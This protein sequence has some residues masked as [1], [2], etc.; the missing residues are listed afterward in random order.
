MKS[1]QPTLKKITWLVLPLSAVGLGLLLANGC[2][3]ETAST[4]STQPVVSA[5]KNSFK[6]VT[7]RLDP[8]GS[9]Y[10]Y[11][12]TE[13]LLANLSD[14]VSAW[15]QTVLSMPN[16]NDEARGNVARAFDAAT[17]LIAQSG[18]EDVSGF[19]M[20]SIATE[21]G[22][23]H[24]KAFLHHYPDKGT[25]FLWKIMGQQPH[26]LTGLEMLPTNTAMATFSDADL[27]LVWSVIQKQASQSGFPQA[28]DF[29]NKLPEE[30]QKVTGLSL[31]TV[32]NSLGGEFGFVITLDPSRMIPVPLP[33]SEPLQVPEPGLMLV[34]K[35]K[36]DTVFNRIDQELS[37]RNRQIVRI[38]KSNLKMRTMPLPLP[39]PIQLRP[40]I[41][42]SDGYLFVATTDTLIQEVLAVK[43]GQKPGLKATDEFKHLAKDMP[44][45]GNRFVFMSE[46]FGRTILQIQ[47]ET[48]QRNGKVQPAQQQLLQSLFQPGTAGFCYSVSANT[49]EGW[50]TVG[51][52]SQSP[53]NTLVAFS[54][55][56]PAA[57]AA[58]AIPNFVKAR[59]VAQK[60]ACI[61]NL[62]QLDA[63]KAQWALENN[64]TGND[65]PTMDDLRPF[66]KGKISCPAGGHYTLGTVADR[67]TC[68]IPGH[69]LEH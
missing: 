6:E 22:L 45:E 64:K 54:A 7:S 20:S 44:V 52:S 25:G 59:E 17:N 55:A 34:V 42:S 49:D 13:Q 63:A 51:N 27:P 1:N 62:R 41:A 39:L 24:S 67:P 9:L 14:R 28:Q 47:R 5:E 53:A 43:S 31:E 60:N 65:M 57:L 16:L 48:L 23:Y 21:P 8:G 12:S 40:T 19:G 69:T 15:R 66:L 29:V 32:L 36:D 10:L 37:K 26:P 18:V 30:F 11:L 46:R 50:L 33:T 2:K 68:S 56:V 35:V 38:D 61:N 3:K 58:I 4:P